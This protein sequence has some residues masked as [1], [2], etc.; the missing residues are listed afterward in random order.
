MERRSEADALFTV[1]AAVREEA[2]TRL[3]AGL[4]ARGVT[5]LLPA[6]EAVLRELFVK[7]PLRMG[8]IAEKINRRKNTVTGLVAALEARG[9]CRREPGAQDAR[10]QLISLTTKGESLRKEQAGLTEELLRVA[11]QGVGEP[12]KLICM[13]A[14]RRVLRNLKRR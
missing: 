6:H 12:E 11:W 9:Y 1:V 5:D 14:L 8:E 4:R 7:S 13:F 3:A 10:M 2:N